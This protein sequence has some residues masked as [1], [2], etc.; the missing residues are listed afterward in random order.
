MKYLQRLNVFW[1]IGNKRVI[2]Q[3]IPFHTSYKLYLFQIVILLIFLFWL[4]RHL[5]IS[6]MTHLNFSNL[7]STKQELFVI[8]HLFHSWIVYHWCVMFSPSASGLLTYSIGSWTLWPLWYQLPY[9]LR[10]IICIAFFCFLCLNCSISIKASFFF[11]S[12]KLELHSNKCQ[13]YVFL[14]SWL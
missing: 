4:L 12:L 6:I 8:V 13:N 2:T 14:R 7:R 11:L 9:T 3:G 10:E 5:F 1:E